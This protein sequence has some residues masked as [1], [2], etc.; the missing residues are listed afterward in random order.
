MN[1]SPPHFNSGTIPALASAFASL[2]VSV[3][4]SDCVNLLAAAVKQFVDVDVFG[5][6]IKGLQ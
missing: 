6:M 5:C 4:V 3:G 2:A 1:E